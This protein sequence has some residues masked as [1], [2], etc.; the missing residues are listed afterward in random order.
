MT[1]LHVAW[2]KAKYRKFLQLCTLYNSISHYSTD[3]TSLCPFNAEAIV[4]HNRMHGFSVWIMQMYSLIKLTYPLFQE[5][6]ATTSSH[7]LSKR[8][9]LSTRQNSFQ[10]FHVLCLHGSFPK[11]ELWERWDRVPKARGTEGAEGVGVCPPP[12]QERGLGRKIDFE[13]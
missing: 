2:N 6:A 12:H 8:M 7:Q 9:H 13:S 3:M 5:N 10:A 11:K 1:H 4:T